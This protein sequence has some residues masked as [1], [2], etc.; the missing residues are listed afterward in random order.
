MGSFNKILK[1]KYWPKVSTKSTNKLGNNTAINKD[2]G[3]HAHIPQTSYYQ[4][5]KKQCA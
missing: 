5:T 1:I 3:M 4:Q 2:F